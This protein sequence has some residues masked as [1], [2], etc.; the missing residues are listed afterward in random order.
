MSQVFI[1]YSRRDIN[2]AQRLA[3]KLRELDFHVWMDDRIKTSTDWWQQ[4]HKALTECTAYIVIMSPGSEES[5]WV[6]REIT[7]AESLKKWAFP[8]LLE[9]DTNIAMSPIWS[10]FVRTQYTIVENH[11]LP[12]PSFFESLRLA[13]KENT[14]KVRFDGYYRC[15]S[16][17]QQGFNTFHHTYGIIFKTDQ[18][19]IEYSE[20]VTG[21]QIDYTHIL[22]TKN[23]DEGTYSISGDIITIY[24]TK[25]NL[26]Y[27]QNLRYH[28][29]IEGDSLKLEIDEPWRERGDYKVPWHL[30]TRRLYNFMPFPTEEERN[31]TGFIDVN[32]DTDEGAE[33]TNEE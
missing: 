28:G 16:R 19:L 14:S 18:T 22:D 21:M 26:A 25:P 11:E 31:R 3:S 33:D 4:I 27:K 2:Y 17:S 7:I 20:I 32:P 1:S 30:K 12:K 24:I 23:P 29:Y 6:Q 15:E 13:V 5:D 8:I 9:G 10:I